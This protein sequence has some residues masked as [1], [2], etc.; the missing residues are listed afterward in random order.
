M[1]HCRYFTRS[2]VTIRLR[3]V[4]AYESCTK[5]VTYTCLVKRHSY[6]LSLIQNFC[7]RIRYQYFQI[8]LSWL[9]YMPTYMHGILFNEKRSR[10]SHTLNRSIYV[11]R[12]GLANILVISDRITGSIK[13]KYCLQLTSVL[14][15]RPKSLGSRMSYC[16]V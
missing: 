4:Y 9:T 5:G 14:W 13:K 1:V 7:H 8:S 10:I 12:A 16:H 3:H 15:A 11:R 6:C 2:V